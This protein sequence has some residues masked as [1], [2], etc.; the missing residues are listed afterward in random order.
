[1]LLKSCLIVNA[2]FSSLVLALCVSATVGLPL[3]HVSWWILVGFA[4]PTVVANRKHFRLRL[5]LRSIMAIMVANVAIVFT[6]GPNSFRGFFPSR[7]IDTWVY[8]SIGQYLTDYVQGSQLGLPAIDQFSSFYSETRF[9]TPSLLGFL[10]V[11]FHLNTASALLLMILIS[12][13]NGLLGFWLL[14]SLLGAGDLIA[15][16]SGVFFVLFG[17]TSDAIKIGNLDNLLFLSLSGTFVARMI[18]IVRGCRSWQALAA[19]TINLAALFYC[20]PEGFVLTSVIMIP[21]TIRIGLFAWRADRQLRRGL[22]AV[23]AATLALAAPYLPTWIAF[24]SIQLSGMNAVSRAG[25]ELFPGLLSWNFLPALLGLGQ[26][27]PG[28][29]MS[30]QSV[31]LVVGAAILCVPGVLSLRSWRIAVGSALSIALGLGVLQ[32]VYL[33]YDY[34]LYKI[35]FLS[36]V[37]WI[38]AIFVGVHGLIRNLE[39]NKRFVVGA[40]SCVFLQSCFLLEKFE[41]RGANPYETK[42]KIK[43]Y[44]QIQYL[45]RITREQPVVLDCKNDFEYRWGLFL[46]GDSPLGFWSIGAIWKD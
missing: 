24:L 8:A 2:L 28:T 30:L 12:L 44:E 36:S 6:V 39:A 20:Y 35:I 18:L 42:K 37:L 27:F 9:G 32:G 16:G 4:I 1:M 26:E 45:G 13:A 5:R 10:S 11:V 23:V 33:R 15:L 19:F 43:P 29:A 25:G 17:W 38:P 46:P 22:I 34:G 21:F 31:I 41:N 40:A 7:T 3:C 14:T